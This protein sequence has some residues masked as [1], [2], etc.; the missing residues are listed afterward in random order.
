MSIW[1]TIRT[2]LTKDNLYWRTAKRLFWIML[3]FS[4]FRL[5]F[6]AF[7]ASL[8]PDLT[9][10]T[11]LRLALGGL[12]FD[13]TAVLYTNLLYL[14]LILVPFQFR[15]NPGYQ[16]ALRI[17]FFVT[18]A[19]ALAFVC[20]DIGYFP[21][22]KHRATATIFGEFSNEMGRATDFF[23]V[24]FLDFWYLVLLWAAGVLFIVWSYGKPVSKPR[25]LLPNG[26]YHVGGL[27][28]MAFCAAFIV[29]GLRG[30]FGES[31]RPITLQ[32]AG[33]YTNKPMELALVLNTPFSI[34]KTF[35]TR[36]LEVEHYFDNADLEKRYS[37]VHYPA[38]AEPFQ[39]LNVV[40]LV[41]ESMGQEFI[42]A[43]NKDLDG[44]KYKGYTPFLD[45][46]V[47]V[48][49]TAKWTFANGDRSIAG[50][51]SVV[52][53]IPLVQDPFVTSLYSGNTV[54][55]LAW[56]LRRKGYHTA[57]FHGAPNGSMGFW[58]FLNLAGYQEYYG[59]DEF[60]NNAEY[61]GIWGIWDEPF[62][63]YMA[64][65]IGTFK[66]PFLATVF[67]LT[68][69]HPFQIPAKYE[70]K[71]PE[72]PRPIYKC[73]GYTDHAL[74]EFFRNAS[75]QPWYKNTLFVLTA[76]HTNGAHH[77][78]YKTDLGF[79]RVPIL[80]YRPGS[81]LRGYD[82]NRIIQQIDVMPTVLNY[83][84]YDEPYFAF[85]KDA[86]ATDGKN[87]AFQYVGQSYQYVQDDY[88]LRYEPGKPA[89][90]FNYRKDILLKNNLGGQHLPAEKE[91][92]DQLKAFVQQYAERMVRNELT[93][94]VP[95]TAQT[96]TTT[97]RR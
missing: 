18:N 73:I 12:K 47:S 52:A 90:L 74:R 35:E 44:G 11:Y 84:H 57:F 83:L 25:K 24:F 91:M 32:N 13:T 6:Y 23:K 42:G 31:V 9:L 95:Q 15:Y 22:V 69:H 51:P 92:T 3:L 4:L 29:A 30:G 68:S 70:G 81:D 94:P 41:V 14:F 49:R 62:L 16:K 61:D 28:V 67:T 17:L 37:P 46:L 36:Q 50:L 56:H 21:F 55:S 39:P 19:V 20:I 71:F 97:P 8:Y 64:N 89:M 80:F 96:L 58:A 34:Y 2:S 33:D 48:S 43:L 63:Q 27:L 59:K 82:T 38:P 87:W 10:A 5:L 85:G 86:F 66:E 78:E 88:V 1:S 76:D 60:N 77:P 93:V 72:G 53:S 75:Q 79:F 26:Y 45:S 65:K 40:T 54:H 7:N